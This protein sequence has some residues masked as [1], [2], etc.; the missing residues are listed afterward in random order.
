MLRDLCVVAIGP[1]AFDEGATGAGVSGLGD[2]A[3]PARVAARVLGG[4][5]TDE[6]RELA[7]VVETSEVAELGDDGEGHNPLNPAQS[8]EGFDDGVEAPR[9]CEFEKLL[10]NAL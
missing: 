5:Q 8:L 7:R 1:S 3:L 6:G 9:R 2:G 10:F 4:D